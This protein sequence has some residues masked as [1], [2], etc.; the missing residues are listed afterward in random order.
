MKQSP[1]LKLV[2]A[3]GTS[4]ALT[5]LRPLICRSL[6]ALRS[7]V[8]TWL[9]PEATP[10]AWIKQNNKAASFISV[11]F[12]Q[13]YLFATAEELAGEK[14]SLCSERWAKLIYCLTVLTTNQTDLGNTAAAELSGVSPYL[15]EQMS[16]CFKGFSDE[17]GKGKHRIY[18]A[19]LHHPEDKVMLNHTVRTKISR[20]SAKDWGKAEEYAAPVQVFITSLNSEVWVFLV[21]GYAWREEPFHSSPVEKKCK[22]VGRSLSSSLRQA[23]L[24][25]SNCCVDCDKLQTSIMG[26]RLTEQWLPKLLLEGHSQEIHYFILNTHRCLKISF[27]R[28]CFWKWHNKEADTT[29]F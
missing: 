21:P 7:L 23:E 5:T 17:W 2:Q 24:K 20:L 12:L 14:N 16:L 1:L 8:T 11:W 10:P 27:Q 19:F 26:K 28:F 29:A 18:H 6:W 25:A 9:N 22:R 3:R 13:I 15:Q 4:V